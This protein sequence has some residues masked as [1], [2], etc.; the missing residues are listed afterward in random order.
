MRLKLARFIQP[1]AAYSPNPNGTFR[2]ASVY[3]LPA[4]GGHAQAK[5]SPA[6]HKAGLRLITFG[7]HK[8]LTLETVYNSTSISYFRWIKTTASSPDSSQGLTGFVEYIAQREA[9]IAEG[10]EEV[11]TPPA[12]PK[13]K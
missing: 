11:D 1:S 12:F 3:N 8:G 13:R 9:G 7:K 6:V 2:D 4:G 5:G 10:S